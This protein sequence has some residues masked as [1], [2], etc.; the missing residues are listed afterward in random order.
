MTSR[1]ISVTLSEDEQR[2]LRDL[3]G[4]DWIR[5]TIAQEHKTLPA[6]LKSRPLPENTSGTIRFRRWLPYHSM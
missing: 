6:I 5:R 1:R 2:Q 4:R 3:G